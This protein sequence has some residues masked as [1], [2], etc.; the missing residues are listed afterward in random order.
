MIVTFGKGAVVESSDIAFAQI[1]DTQIACLR[2]QI[3]I[4]LKNCSCMHIYYDSHEK[5]ERELERLVK[6]MKS[7]T[8][9]EK[10]PEKKRALRKIR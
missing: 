5:A 1:R 4:T 10:K 9:S 6:A 3:Q 2:P 7:G 8:S